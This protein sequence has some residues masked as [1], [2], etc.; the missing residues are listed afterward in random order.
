MIKTIM[1]KKTRTLKVEIVN[2]TDIAA[3]FGIHAR[4]GDTIELRY[5]DKEGE[6]HEVLQGE[7]KEKAHFTKATIFKMG[8]NNKIGYGGLFEGEKKK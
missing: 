5:R 4:P 3:P 7:I 6:E 1:K 8:K 2:E